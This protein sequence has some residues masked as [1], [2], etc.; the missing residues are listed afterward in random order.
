ML[1]NRQSRYCL[2]NK[3]IIICIL[4]ILW[5]LVFILKNKRYYQVSKLDWMP[6]KHKV[7]ENASAFDVAAATADASDDDG[8][9]ESI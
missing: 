5:L 7:L 4:D 3:N 8:D 6:N 9:D 2:K 1:G